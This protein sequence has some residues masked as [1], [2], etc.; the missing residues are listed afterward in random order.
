MGEVF[1]KNQG[2]VNMSLEPADPNGK[3]GLWV[4]YVLIATFVGFTSLDQYKKRTDAGTSTPSEQRG[5]DSKNRGASFPLNVG[6]LGRSAPAGQRD[7]PRSEITADLEILSWRC[8]SEHGYMHTVGQVRNTSGRSLENVMVIGQYF[9]N[10]GDF[11]KKA[12]ALI[13]FNPLLSGQTS[14]FEALTTHNPEIKK[15]NLTFKQMGRGELTTTTNRTEPHAFG[16]DFIIIFQ[17]RLTELGFNP[18]AHDGIMGPRTREAIEEFQRSEGLRV[19]GEVTPE[20]GRALFS[21]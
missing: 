7:P 13:D 20:T 11:I 8:Y 6:S 5:E 16:K 21:D 9:A 14:S 17:R 19:T 15:C 10:S 2:G 4:G 1:A 12:D 18:G 3:I